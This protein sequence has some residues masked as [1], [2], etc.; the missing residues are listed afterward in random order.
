MHSKLSDEDILN[1]LNSKSIMNCL[2]ILWETIE[3]H[4]LLKKN[5]KLISTFLQSKYFVVLKRF[6]SEFIY[7]TPH[8]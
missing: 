1:E 2:N 3:I 8:N 5:I 6:V 4:I 7:Y